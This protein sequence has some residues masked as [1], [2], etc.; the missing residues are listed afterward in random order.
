KGQFNYTDS[1]YANDPGSLNLEQ[2]KS[3]RKNAR[4]ANILYQTTEKINHLKVGLSHEYGLK[5]AETSASN[6]KSLNINSYT[7]FAQRN[8]QGLLPFLNGGVSA[9]KRSYYGLGTK[10][11]FKGL[12]NEQF[13]VG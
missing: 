7:F 1:P 8:F 12:K 3:N 10:A 6:K 13:I 9:F 5:L 11:I 4:E 2:V